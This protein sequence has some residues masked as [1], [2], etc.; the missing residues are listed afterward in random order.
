MR[1][2]RR[3]GNAI[4][5]TAP[6]EAR[7]H[8]LRLASGRALLGGAVTACPAASGGGVHRGDAEI[9]TR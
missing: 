6:E 8:V 3:F 2:L 9:R 1:V 5:V 7:Q 4:T